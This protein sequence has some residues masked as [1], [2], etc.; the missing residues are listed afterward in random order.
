MS[1]PEFP[2]LR[3]KTHKIIADHTKRIRARKK[4]GTIN[5]EELLLADIY[6]KAL[7][8]KIKPWSEKRISFIKSLRAALWVV[9]GPP[10]NIKPETLDLIARIAGY[11]FAAHNQQSKAAKAL[12]KKTAIKK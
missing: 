9:E 5:A 4:A 8:Q 12:H 3:A 10:F 11:E 6:L 7:H 2:R 1:A